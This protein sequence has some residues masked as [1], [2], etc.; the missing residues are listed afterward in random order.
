MDVTTRSQSLMGTTA[1]VS[2]VSSRANQLLEAVFQL[3]RELEQRF[4]ANAAD[5]ELMAV[6]QQAGK[7]PVQVHP[8][9]FELIELGKEHSL[10][11]QSSLNIAI[12]PLVNAWR[13]GF[14]DARRP[15]EQE[16]RTA[17]A[18]T[19][20]ELIELDP[21]NS[22]VF[23]KEA[24]MKIDL[25]ALAKGYSA[26]RVASFLRQEG[27][28]SA[29]INLGGNILTIGGRKNRPWRIGI[30]DPLQPR[31]RYLLNLPIRSQSV[32]TSGIYERYL[33]LDGRRFHHILDRESGY[34]LDSQL[35][36]LTIISDRSVD[37]EIWTSRLFGQEPRSILDQVRQQ[38]GLEAILVNRE[39]QVACSEG[40]RTLL[41]HSDIQKEGKFYDKRN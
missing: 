5:S 35:A 10:A 23:L 2:L 39:G 25:G 40:V 24:G 8:D 20:P 31:G 9:L 30:Q 38:E 4:S 3:L 14:S 33:E 37:G 29:L 12:G 36:S 32:V 22:S 11:P 17:L 27:V 26:D 13:I 21:S 19:D 6:N 28:T 16:I 34:P 1:S 18:L 7:M 15:Q 41:S